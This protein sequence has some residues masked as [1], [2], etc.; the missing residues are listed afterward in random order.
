MDDTGRARLDAALDLLADEVARRLAARTPLDPVV[1]EPAEATRKHFAFMEGCW[2][3]NL[4]VKNKSRIIVKASTYTLRLKTL[5]R[6]YP[7]CKLIYMVRDPVD[8]IPS[9]MSIGSRTSSGW[10]WARRRKR[11]NG[12]SFSGRTV[13]RRPLWR[14]N[15]TSTVRAGPG[16]VTTNAVRRW[17]LSASW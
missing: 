10:L 4:L 5:L 12:E 1:D 11:R 15:Q 8:T 16:S 2:R 6:R 3:R 13:K 9:G 7:S 14:L 17:R